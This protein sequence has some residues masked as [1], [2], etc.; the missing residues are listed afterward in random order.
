MSFSVPWCVSPSTA[1]CR[2]VISAGVVVSW[3]VFGAQLSVAQNSPTDPSALSPSA[4]YEL[5][6]RAIS[7]YDKALTTYDSTDFAAAVE[8]LEKAVGHNLRDGKNWIRLGDSRY[9][10]GDYRG[11]IDAYKEARALGYGFLDGTYRFMDYSIAS[12]YAELGDKTKA[13]TWFERSLQEERFPVRRLPLQQTAFSSLHESDRLRS[14]AG[15]TPEQSFDSR[16][17]GWRY[18]LKFL[19]SE[20]RRLNATYSERP[21]P[22]SIERAADQ[23][24]ADI[25]NLS[26]G[27]IWVRFQ[28]LLAKL[29]Q[30]HNSVWHFE[31]VERLTI[32]QLP[33]SFYLFEDG[34]HVMDAERKGLIG[35]KVQ[36]IGGTPTD[37]AL[38]AVRSVVT[39]ET[40]MKIKWL[41]PV[42][43]RMPQV[44]RV[45]GII[46][47]TSQVELT[48]ESDDGSSQ[49]IS[50]EPV[51]IEPRKKLIPSQHPNAGMPP[52]Y[53]S[54]P[55]D[56]YWMEERPNRGL[57]YVQVNQIRNEEEESFADFAARLRETLKANETNHLVV[58]LR[59]NNGGNTFLY[60]ELLRTLVWFDVK[61]GTDLYV[62]VGR[63]TYSAAQNLAT[64]LDR[65]TGAVFVGEPTGGR[66]NTHGDES[67]VILPY[68]GLNLGLS[69]SYWQHSD[70]RDDRQWIAPDIPV[71]LSSGDYFD[72]HDPV[73]ET[74]RK[75]IGEK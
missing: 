7:L 44:L 30:S 11:A 18:D 55:A 52:L 71:S 45:A 61:V 8:P 70:P 72:N 48:L 14:L 42:Y 3:A 59:R 19:L 22:D 31:E 28:Q 58:D 13:L 4:Y 50:M 66:P 34:L 35:A 74:L 46:N 20:V 64:D 40:P 75:V 6:Q 17:E 51:P 27:E 38:D 25:P 5:Q 57:I 43:L 37:Q 65:L 12:S 9:Y 67:H 56:P 15:L 68:S 47:D 1:S 63:N 53:L 62:V 10:T 24:R 49:Q 41:G 29:G 39:S 2:Y 16:V 21:L 60:T 73:M 26:D 54:H 69:T 23:L 32:T 33:L 36:A